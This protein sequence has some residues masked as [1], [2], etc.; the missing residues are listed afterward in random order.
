MTRSVPSALVLAG[1]LA[2]G[3]SSAQTPPSTS[4]VDV[5]VTDLARHLVEGLTAADFEVTE[6]GRP[7]PVVS[8]TDV[9]ARAGGRAYLIAID[10]VHLTPQGAARVQPVLEEFIRDFLNP[11]DRAAVAWLTP[12]PRMSD[13]TS[14]RQRLLQIVDAVSDDARSRGAAAAGGIGL[15]FGSVDSLDATGQTL[16]ALSAALARGR[17]AV[18]HPFAV[19]LISGGLPATESEPRATSDARRALFAEAARANAS[20]YPIDPAGMS[21]ISSSLAPSEEFEPAG[22]AEWASLRLIADRT[23]GRAIVGRSDLASAYR[24]IVQD[25]S[26]YCLITYQSAVTRSGD[27]RVRVKRPGVKVRTGK[28]N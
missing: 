15:E 17:R 9:D 2:G 21:S 16:S 24:E 5:V 4:T 1:F 19:L 27:V 28:N 14:D 12:S 8:C 25:S 13:F 10:A 26:G 20:I 11:R 3:F 6:K 22:L 23:G 7:V 18:G